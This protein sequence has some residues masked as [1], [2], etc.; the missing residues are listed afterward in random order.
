M[1]PSASQAANSS[2]RASTE[3]APRRLPNTSWSSP[4]DEGTYLCSLRTMYRILEEAGEVRERRDQLQHPQ[5]QK[6]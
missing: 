1:P 5:Y 4:L 3:P 2:T 6:S